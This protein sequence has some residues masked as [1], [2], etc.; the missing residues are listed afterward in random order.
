[1]TNRLLLVS[2]SIL[3][4]LIFVGCQPT[5]KFIY[6]VDKDK[7]FD[8]LEDYKSFV[9]RKT[10]LDTDKFYLVE[11]DNLFNLMEEFSGKSFGYY[12]GTINK[13]KLVADGLNSGIDTSCY[14]SVLNALKSN[15]MHTESPKDCRI[16][17]YAY[18][19]FSK[20]GVNLDFEEDTAVFLF[21]YKRGRFNN[22][23]L[24]LIEEVRSQN[25]DYI[26][27]SVD[28]HYIKDQNQNPMLKNQMLLPA[29]GE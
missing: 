8:S 15:D 22:D 17:N 1:M 10:K 20:Q 14:G 4:S 26:I 21:T 24:K 11:N 7:Y 6:G 2:L 25:K 13:G 9:E 19:T 28:N 23:I 27:L 29:S 5:L 16:V 3:L 12:Y 18:I